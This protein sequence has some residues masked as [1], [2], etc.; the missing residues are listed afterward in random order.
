MQICDIIKPMVNRFCPN[1]NMEHTIEKNR[2]YCDMNCSRMSKI[3]KK[4][5]GSNVLKPKFQKQID[6]KLNEP[7]PTC[8][9]GQFFIM[10]FVIPESHKFEAGEPPTMTTTNNDEVEILYNLTPCKKCGFLEGGKWHIKK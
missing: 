3:T 5:D 6:K 7:L 10:F 4:V 8:F 2:K 9:E 1:C